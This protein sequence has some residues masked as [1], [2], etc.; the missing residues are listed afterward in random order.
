M[1]SGCGVRGGLPTQLFLITCL[2]CVVRQ[3]EEAALKPR[4]QSVS[5]IAGN[6]TPVNVSR[7]VCGYFIPVTNLRKYKDLKTQNHK[8][9]H[10]DLVQLYFQFS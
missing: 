5:E 6:K 10:K 9:K 2:S 3:P 7:C 4:K 1:G 8:L